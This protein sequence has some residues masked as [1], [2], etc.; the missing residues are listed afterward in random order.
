MRTRNPTDL[1]LTKKDV[2]YFQFP[3]LFRN[4]HLM[5][6]IFT[7]HGGV[8]SPPFDSLNISFSV[9][10]RADD[11]KTNI[12][13]I[14]DIIGAKDLIQMNQVHG[15][16]IL[17]LHQGTPLIHDKI[18]ST[19]AIITEI[20]WIALLVK[21]ADCQGIIIYDPE[22][23]VAAGVHCGWRGNV[24][25]ILGTVVARMKKEFGCK[26]TNMQAAIG[27]S[28]GP[29]CA[30]FISYKDIFP[31]EFKNFMAPK[32]HFDLWSVSCRQL[33][34]AGLKAKNIEVAGI[35]TKC[36]TDKFYSYRAE[37]NTGRFGTVVMLSRKIS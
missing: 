9:K 19:D 23:H 21:Q 13:K 10:D 30:E 35:C 5:H 28:L 31:E 6:G 7:R 18:P 14:K 24:L 29:C 25:N 36:R 27:P 12:K 22:K 2:V 1:I 8:S 3:G 20:P 34:K 11:V 26:A 15:D 16:D 4:R 17:V 33:E 37:T 32:N